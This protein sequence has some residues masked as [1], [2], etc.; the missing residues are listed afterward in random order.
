MAAYFLDLKVRL[1]LRV[2]ALAAVCF[3]AAVICVLYAT[4]RTIRERTDSIAGVVA[5]ELALQSSQLR[6]LK[7]TVEPSLDLQL[8]SQTV[9]EPGLCI[10]Y[11]AADGQVVQRL[12]DGVAAADAMVPPA[13]TA[14][15]TRAFGFGTQ[16]IRPVQLGGERHGD[17]IVSIDSQRVIAEA[18]RETSGLITVLTMTWFA[19]CLLTYATLA[20]ALRPIRIIRA[21]LQRLASGDL[22]ARLPAFDLAELSPV[23]AVFNS[24]AGNLDDALAE[25]RTFKQRLIAVQDDERRHLARELHDEFGQC[26]AAISAM[27]VSAS[28]TAQHRAPEILPEFEHISRTVERMMDI[29]RG[30]LLRLRP[31][32]IEEL[33]LVAS[34]EGLVASW[35]G[36]DRKT[37]FSIEWDGRFDIVPAPLAASIYR[38]AQEAITNTAK[39]A[40]ASRVL[41]HL[42]LHPAIESGDVARVEMRIDDNGQAEEKPDVSSGMGLLGIRERIEALG[43]QFA[44]QV[45]HPSGL[46]LRVQIPL[47]TAVAREWSERDHA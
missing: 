35:N 42:R 20:Y 19:L 24:L 23:S 11:R 3:M 13:F 38:I 10:G 29:L 15:Y 28:Q 9:K 34:L 44:I 22:S 2:A 21:G 45:L 14:L 4:N 33:G 7:N 36:G 18:W 5:R 39:H 46:R 41:L 8:L 25:R 47:S 6:W 43:G 12:C 17:A 27:T 16:S 31:P 30:T 32:E 37:R 1:A 40:H 26:L